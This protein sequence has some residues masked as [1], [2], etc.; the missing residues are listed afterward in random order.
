MSRIY[1]ALRKA[2]QDRAPNTLAELDGKPAGSIPRDEVRGDGAVPATEQIPPPTAWGGAR[3]IPEYLRLDDL[4]QRCAKPRWTPDANRAVFSD[5]PHSKLVA[6]QF[7][8]LRSRVYRLREKLPLRSLLITSALPREGKT[9]VA[10]NLAEAIVRQHE[11]RAL[12][13]DADLRSSG[14]HL[15]LGAPPAPG[16]ADYLRGEVDECSVI[17]RSCESDANFFFIPGGRPVSNPA[18]LL[19]N[20]R[21]KSLLERLAPVF[22]W[23]ILDSPPAL[24]VSDASVLAG[25]CDGVLLIVCAGLTPFD[26]AQKAYQE[27]RDKN[28]LGVILNRA[29]EMRYAGYHYYA[30][31]GKD[32]R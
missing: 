19:A 29:D 2:E 16:L 8:T 31:D 21:L 1:E 5:T 25:V 24:P 26:S 3:P 12:L 22:D 14:L 30:G 28:L 4:R 18:E 7:R 9:F 32:K 20:G 17:Q 13:I 27:F 10:V 15:P 11:R 6:E 23:I